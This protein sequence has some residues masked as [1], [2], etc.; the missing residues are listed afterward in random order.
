MQPRQ[1]F[2]VYSPNGTRVGTY[3]TNE[4]GPM[5]L[6][7]TSEIAIQMEN[8]TSQGYRCV[9]T[10]HY[11]DEFVERC[12]EICSDYYANPGYLYDARDLYLPYSAIYYY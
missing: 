1:L 6:Y 10:T 12:H 8:L 2:H 4:W 3:C 7:H 9:L 5:C 11:F